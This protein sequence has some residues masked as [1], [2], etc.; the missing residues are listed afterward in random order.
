MAE[1]GRFEP[2]P[3]DMQQASLPEAV[4]TPKE[5]ADPGAAAKPSEPQSTTT[6]PRTEAASTSPISTA[7]AKLDTKAPSW[8]Q[9]DRVNRGVRFPA[10]QLSDANLDRVHAQLWHKPS[11]MKWQNV[12]WHTELEDAMDEARRV[13]RPILLWTM[14]GHPCGET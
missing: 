7:T 6:P 2:R 9:L 10:P 14:N 11:E 5:I 12:R 8:P 3:E 4:P 13:Q 1:A